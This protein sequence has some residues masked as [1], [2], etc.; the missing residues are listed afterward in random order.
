MKKTPEIRKYPITI[1]CW[2]RGQRGRQ[3]GRACVNHDG[4]KQSYMNKTRSILFI[5]DSRR[6]VDPDP[7][8]LACKT[9]LNR[10]LGT[11][12]KTLNRVIVMCDTLSDL[13]RRCAIQGEHRACAPFL[14]LC[15][16]FSY[17]YRKILEVLLKLMKLCELMGA[18]AGLEMCF[19]PTIVPAPHSYYYAVVSHTNTVK[20]WK[21]C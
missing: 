12:L 9:H 11:I 15:C 2:G 18:G 8:V 21:C 6:V 7:S 4:L 19:A 17:K 1:Q 5:L 10:D 14:L 13:T 20:Y 16:G 3:R